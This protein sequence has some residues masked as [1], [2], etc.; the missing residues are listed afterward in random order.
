MVPAM[1]VVLDQLPTTPNGKLDR[2][3]L[4]EPTEEN[5]LQ[6][7]TLEA[8]ATAIEERLEEI[9]ASLLGM[10]HVSVE[11]NFFMLGGHSLLGT[12]VIARVSATFGVDL[13]LRS[14]FE[15]PSVRSLA[16]KVEEL[17]ME[18]LAVMS[19]EEAQQ[20]LK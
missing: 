17:I 5:M 18:K 19:E 8:P 16:A 2:K 15:A 14:L 13:S 12:Q 1:F 3:A 10:T 9:V 6:D 20:L 11:D 4:P 7:E